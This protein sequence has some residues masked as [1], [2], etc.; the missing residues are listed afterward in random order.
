MAADA[1]NG[2]DINVVGGG[3]ATT[4]GGGSTDDELVLL[5][6]DARDEGGAGRVAP[7]G[8]DHSL[9]DGCGWQSGIWMTEGEMDRAGMIT[10]DSTSMREDKANDMDS[11][12]NSGHSPV[13]LAGTRGGG[14]S[15]EL[16]L[17][18]VAAILLLWLLRA[19]K[20]N[21][22]CRSPEGVGGGKSRPAWN[23]ALA[24]SAN[25]D[26]LLPGNSGSDCLWIPSPSPFKAADADVTAGGRD[27]MTLLPSPSSW[28]ASWSGA[29]GGGG[30]V[31][32]A[33]GRGVEIGT[34]DEE[35]F[36]VFNAALLFV[37]YAAR[38]G[39]ALAGVEGMA[40]LVG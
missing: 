40:V 16:L 23:M 22:E 17:I 38:D 30:S 1:P 5:W 3:V 34:T 14:K 19:F 20:C 31:T 2:S 21:C 32:G 13:A 37:R 35:G 33:G 12:P 8:N 18:A 26:T 25:A 4:G 9:S 29:G 36:V 7:T 15:N 27:K 28:S 39:S 24:D 10:I 6:S 11:S